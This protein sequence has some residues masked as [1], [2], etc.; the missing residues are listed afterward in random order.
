MV[1]LCNWLAVARSDQK[2]KLRGGSGADGWMRKR[3]EV[4]VGHCA[5]R[6]AGQRISHPMGEIHCWVLT[7]VGVLR[8]HEFGKIYSNCV[9]PISTQSGLTTMTL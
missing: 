2:Y 1:T 5:A 3:H 6:A 9:P 8:S 7:V 4:V